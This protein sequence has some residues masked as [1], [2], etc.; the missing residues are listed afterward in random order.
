MNRTERAQLAIH[1]IDQ[2]CRPP[3]DLDERQRHE[4]RDQCVTDDAPALQKPAARELR[5]DP[6]ARAVDV[7]RRQDALFVHRRCHGANGPTGRPS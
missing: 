7:E 4:Q 6:V 3:A 5:P 2:Q 1:E